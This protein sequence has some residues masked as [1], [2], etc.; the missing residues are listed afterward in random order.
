MQIIE[1]D[2]IKLSDKKDKYKS[3]LKIKKKELDK[4]KSIREKYPRSETKG[5][6]ICKIFI[7]VL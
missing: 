6:H 4:L 7:F 2:Y 1:A 3:K 5:M